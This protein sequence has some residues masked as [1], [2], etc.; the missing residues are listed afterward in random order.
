MTNTLVQTSSATDSRFLLRVIAV[1][2]ELR[3]GDQNGVTV[4]DAS[5]GE[6]PKEYALNRT[7]AYALR[8][9]NN[10]GGAG[11]LHF[12]VIEARNVEKVR[13]EVNRQAIDSTEVIEMGFSLRPDSAIPRPA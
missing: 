12:Q 3:L 1:D 10:D 7:S 6:C 4:F 9:N 8:Y 11:V 13:W 5:R 2:L